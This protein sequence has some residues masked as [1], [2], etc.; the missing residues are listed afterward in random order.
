MNHLKQI[1]AKLPEYGID[2]MLVSSAPS[3]FYAV[4]LHGEGYAIITPNATRYITDGRYTEVAQETVGDAAEVLIVGDGRNYAALLNDFIAAHNI[5]KLGI[6]D[7][8]M[9]LGQFNALTDSLKAELVYAGGLISSLRASKDE[10]ELSRMVK[11]QEITDK[12]FDAIIQFIQPGMTEAEIAAR[13]TYEMLRLGAQRMSFDP[14]VASGPNGSRPH[15]IPGP[16]QVQKGDFITMDFGCVYAGYCSDMTRTIALGQISDEQKKVYDTVLAA[17]LAGIAVSRAGVAGSTIHNTAA[18]VI[19]DAGY[20]PYFTHGY[21]HSLGIEIHENPNAN[22]RN[23][24]PL[25]IGAMVSAEPGIYL[26]GRFGV[27]IEDVV[28]MEEGGCLD[29]THSPKELII[30]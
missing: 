30:L 7:D 23:D 26:P 1:A 18:K 11:A 13:L 2:A 4:G 16:R 17:Q 21:G 14:I 29:I 12:A 22:S 20:G 9:S 10:E 19:A 25:P 8:Y 6:E 15:A 27:R 28:R 24:K 5:Q 3:E